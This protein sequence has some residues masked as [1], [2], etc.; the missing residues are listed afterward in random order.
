[1]PDRPRRIL[2]IRRRYLGDIVLLGS[3]LRNLRLH[4]PD[5]HLAVLVEPRFVDLLALNPDVDQAVPLPQSATQWPG[6]LRR[7]R[8]ERFTHVLNLDNTE[9]TAVIARWTGAPIR[10]ALH[11]GGYRLK[12]RPLYTNSVRDDDA[13][14]EANPITEYYLRA[15]EPLGVPVVTREIRL[16]PP[17]EEVAE[18]Q[19]FVGASERVLLVHPGSRSPM[20]VWPAERFAALID[21]AQDELGAQVILAGGP[22]DEAVLTEI[23]RHVGTHLLALPGPLPIARFAALA[24]ISHAL[25]CHDSGP[26]H[27]AAAVGTPVIAL[28]G[29]QNATLFQPMGPNH[30]LLQ[31]PLPCRTCVAPER[32]VPADS[33]HN[34]CVQNIS[35][36]RVREA[37]RARLTAKR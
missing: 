8:R 29:S 4:W 9:K 36:E 2:I 6:F 32:C 13:R 27:V 3:L 28:Y 22:A 34:L 19:R 14:H 16:E 5:A 18:L 11:H 23:R 10:V 30:T 17:A 21:Y 24:R 7:L 15:L 37:V 33:Y 20:R 12:F 25:V 35:L 31:P 26:M 1:M